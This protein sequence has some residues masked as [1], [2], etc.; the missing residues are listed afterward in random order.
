MQDVFHLGDTG[1]RFCHIQHRF[2]C[3]AD[4]PFHASLFCDIAKGANQ[5]DLFLRLIEHVGDVHLEHPFNAITASSNE[6]LATNALSP[7]CARQRKVFLCNRLTME[8]VGRIAFKKCFQLI[9][10]V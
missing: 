2:Q 3:L 1:Y 8:C 10:S 6:T 4:T 9:C 5:A 7:Q